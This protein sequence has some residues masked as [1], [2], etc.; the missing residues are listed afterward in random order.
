MIPH[1]ADPGTVKEAM[2]GDLNACDPYDFR[3]V[4]LRKRNGVN[5]ASRRNLR[6]IQRKRGAATWLAAFETDDP[7]WVR[8]SKRRQD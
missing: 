6:C 3:E 1:D 2:E 8:I 7:H 4:R 5:C